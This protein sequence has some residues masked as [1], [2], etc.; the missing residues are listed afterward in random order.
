[1]SVT[2]TKRALKRDPATPIGQ[3]GKL[4]VDCLCGA[5]VEIQ[6]DA[7]ECTSCGRVYNQG[8]WITRDA[9]TNLFP[10]LT[11]YRVTYDDGSVQ[12]HS[13]AAGVT[14]DEARQH[15]VG[16]RFEVTETTFRTGVS[17]EQV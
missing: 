15:Y 8:G 11:A 10:R 17:V 5:K 1:M 16:T 3:P 7:N 12:V 13:M 14:L 9:L 2:C 4:H 6:R